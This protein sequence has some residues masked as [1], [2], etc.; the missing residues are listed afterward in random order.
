MAK[1][2]EGDDG[3]PDDVLMGGVADEGDGQLPA[4]STSISRALITST[5]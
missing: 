2:V 5:K 3:T 1:A 4:L